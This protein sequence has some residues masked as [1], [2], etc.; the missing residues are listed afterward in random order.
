MQFDDWNTLIE[1]QNS[2]GRSFSSSISISSPRTNLW[3]DLHCL[4]V[5][6]VGR[7]H[8]F[9]I[10]PYNRLYSRITHK[11]FL[12]RAKKTTKRNGWLGK[13]LRLDFK[14]KGESWIE[15]F[16]CVGLRALLLASSTNLL[17]SWQRLLHPTCSL[18]QG[19]ELGLLYSRFCSGMKLKQN[20]KL[21]PDERTISYSY[22]Q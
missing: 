21:L 20:I 9:T 17:P 3:E 15:P 6:A 18:D 8:W 14:A 10:G 2:L 4:L 5:N 22:S 12:F 7:S 16:C 1:M 13:E 19:C 11:R